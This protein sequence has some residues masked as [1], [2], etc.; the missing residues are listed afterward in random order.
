MQLFRQRFSAI[1][2]QALASC[3]GGDLKL[4]KTPLPACCSSD[5]FP[6]KNC[7]YAD[8]VTD[9]IDRPVDISDWVPDC[10]KEVTWALCS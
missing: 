9:L 5:P 8:L 3:I 4:S 6:L 10:L 2:P 1:P 7:S